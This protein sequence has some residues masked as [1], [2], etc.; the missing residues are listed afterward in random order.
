MDKDFKL[1]SVI[2][3]HKKTT[4]ENSKNQA[5][6]SDIIAKVNITF[7]LRI[8]TVITCTVLNWKSYF[9]YYNKLI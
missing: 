7:Y 8:I 9:T 2:L 1:D 6:V 3:R 4:K 5:R